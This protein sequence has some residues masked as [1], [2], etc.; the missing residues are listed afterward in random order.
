VTCPF[1]IHHSFWGGAGGGKRRRVVRVKRGAHVGDAKKR[2][3][4]ADDAREF[5]PSRAGQK[6]WLSAEVLHRYEGGGNSLKGKM[7]RFPFWRKSGN[8]LTWESHQGGNEL[9]HGKG[10][11]LI[12]TVLKTNTCRQRGRRGNTFRWK[13]SVFYR[14][15][16]NR[17]NTRRKKKGR[18]G[19]E[20]K[21]KKPEAELYNR[22]FR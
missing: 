21:R 13:S 11:A 5:C 19:V 9:C 20:K 8:A 14:L 6:N 17:K 7:G 2:T 1:L 15:G 18:S 12:R 22:G 10:V 4:P 16:S 3:S